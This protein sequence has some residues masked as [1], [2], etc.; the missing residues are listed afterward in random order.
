MW[1][2]QGC[3]DSE[4]ISDI[5]LPSAL[6]GEQVQPRYEAPGALLALAKPGVDK[7]HYSSE[8]AGKGDFLCS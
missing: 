6:Q 2:S 5:G 7:W 4:S 8:Q 1:Q 3:G